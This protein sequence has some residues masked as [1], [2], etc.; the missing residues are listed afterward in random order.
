LSASIARRKGTGAQ[1]KSAAR[2]AHLRGAPHPKPGQNESPA[3]NKSDTRVSLLFA[4]GGPSWHCAQ[5]KAPRARRFCLRAVATRQGTLS[6][7][8]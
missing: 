5:T 8:H 7:T 4:R 3:Q 6:V 1:N 2:E